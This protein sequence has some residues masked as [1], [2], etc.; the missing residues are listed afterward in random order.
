MP[1]IVSFDTV[2][3]TTTFPA[4]YDAQI[5]KSEMMKLDYVLGVAIKEQTETEN[6]VEILHFLVEFDELN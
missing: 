3:S 5:V 4:L 2:T 6:T 1:N